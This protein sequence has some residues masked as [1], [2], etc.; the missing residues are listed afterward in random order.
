MQ[1]DP[2]CDRN[3]TVPPEPP[4][5]TTES[6]H[7]HQQVYQDHEESTSADDRALHCSLLVPLQ[8]SGNGT[9]VIFC[10]S[11]RKTAVFFNDIAGQLAPDMPVYSFNWP[12]PTTDNLPADTLPT[13]AEEFLQDLKRCIP[14]GPYI[15]CG[16]CFGAVIAIE[17]AKRL[18]LS[19]EKVDL[20]VMID[21]VRPSTGTKWQ[22]WQRRQLKLLRFFRQHGIRFFIRSQYRK[23]FNLVQYLRSDPDERLGRKFHLAHQRAFHR[24]QVEP[25]PHLAL[26]VFSHAEQQEDLC[27]RFHY[28]E[29][30]WKEILPHHREILILPDCNHHTILSNGA[31]KIAAKIR[32]IIEKISQDE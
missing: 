17:M 30:R 3:V 21:P 24:Y 16:Y 11:F 15:I 18:T 29:E 28:E 8:S 4:S 19:G 12:V 2:S 10:P 14:H 22:R 32:V 23:G 26:L 20:L 31:G 9:T 7:Q 1:A 13:I 25:C 27:V 5:L 6:N